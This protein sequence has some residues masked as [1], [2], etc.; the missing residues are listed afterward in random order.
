MASYA[1]LFVGPNIFLSTLFSNS[2]CLQSLRDQVS[3]QCRILAYFVC[4]CFERANG[5]TPPLTCIEG[6][7]MSV[8]SSRLWH[9]VVSL[10]PHRNFGTVARLYGQLRAKALMPLFRYQPPTFPLQCDISAGAIINGLVLF[11]PPIDRPLH[12]HPHNIMN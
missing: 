4:A 11:S 3:H 1:F 5:K 9:T 7:A 12:F 2:L 10:C 8:H 6:T